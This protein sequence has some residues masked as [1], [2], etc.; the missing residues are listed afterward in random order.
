MLSLSFLLSILPLP[1]LPVVARHPVYFLELQ[2]S[3]VRFLS[4]GCGTKIRAIQVPEKGVLGLARAD[5]AARSANPARTTSD[6]LRITAP[7]HMIASSRVSE[8]DNSVECS[9][10]TLNKEIRGQGEFSAADAGFESLTCRGT[11]EPPRS[12]PKPPRS[13]PMRSPLLHPLNI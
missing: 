10:G 5:Q 4:W 13:L 11:K 3:V 8:K 12:R 7:A 1:T 2:L 6:M 9:L